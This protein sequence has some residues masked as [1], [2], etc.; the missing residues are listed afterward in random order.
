MKMH[1]K[2]K[3]CLAQ[4]LIKCKQYTQKSRKDRVAVEWLCMQ[5]KLTGNTRA[6]FV[7]TTCY[8]DYR[9]AE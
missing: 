6:E 2:H 5:D 4:K 7:Y 9:M 1:L 3:Y 8:I